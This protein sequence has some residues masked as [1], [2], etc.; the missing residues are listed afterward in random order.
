LSY[1]FK[2]LISVK[3]LNIKFLK[4][5]FMLIITHTQLNTNIYLLCNLGLVS[6][7]TKLILKNVQK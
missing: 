1:N 3:S 2:I 4:S 5:K 6:L 7:K